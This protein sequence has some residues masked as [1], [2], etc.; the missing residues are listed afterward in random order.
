MST[1]LDLYLRADARCTETQSGEPVCETH[2]VEAIAAARA[3]GAREERESI[4]VLVHEASI[5]A[6]RDEGH[7]GAACRSI[8]AAIRARKEPA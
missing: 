6:D 5:R 3:E 4:E 2:V 1:D 8:L 7:P